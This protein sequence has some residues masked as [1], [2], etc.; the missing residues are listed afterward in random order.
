MVAVPPKIIPKDEQRR[1]RVY[2]MRT[3]IAVKRQQRQRP[4]WLESTTA[5]IIM[6]RLPPLPSAKLKRTTTQQQQ[7]WPTLPKRPCGACM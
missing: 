4:M 1:H 3:A 6:R 7:P 5:P 2:F